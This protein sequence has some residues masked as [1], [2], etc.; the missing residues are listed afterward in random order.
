[1]QGQYII[2]H[3]LY[4][5]LFKRG[6]HLKTFLA[7]SRITPRLLSGQISLPTSEK[8]VQPWP[9]SQNYRKGPVSRWSTHWLCRIQFILSSG[10]P[11]SVVV[12][13]SSLRRHTV[14]P[15]SSHCCPSVNT[16][17]SLCR[18]TVAPLSSCYGP[19]V[20]T[21]SEPSSEHSRSGAI[22]PTRN[23][24]LHVFRI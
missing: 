9:I 20:V 18:H 6:V 21:L 11:P 12:V 2:Y 4:N 3:I 15:L 14:V 7:Q 13:L 5:I 24:G 16:L 1:M 19:P 10:C 22:A 17:L 8:N 23:P